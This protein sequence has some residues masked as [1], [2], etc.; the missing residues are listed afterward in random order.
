MAEVVS[1]NEARGRSLLRKEAPPEKRRCGHRAVFVAAEHRMLE[2]QNCGAMVDPFDF[3]WETAR[4]ESSLTAEVE[5]LKAKRDALKKE[6]A[7]LVGERT[8]LV[9][10]TAKARREA[11]DAAG[12]LTA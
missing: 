5:A 2:C 12:G 1:L 9:V 6:V 4:E 3:L 7:D 8:S 10:K 11:K